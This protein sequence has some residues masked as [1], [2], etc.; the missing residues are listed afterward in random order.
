MLV[1]GNN[2]I[3]SRLY[4]QLKLEFNNPFIWMVLTYDSVYYLMSNW[5]SMNFDKF[6]I[7]ASKFKNN[8]FVLIIDGKVELHFVHYV[9]DKNAN[10][11]F[12]EQKYTKDGAWYGNV[13]FKNI[14]SYIKEKYISRLNRMKACSEEPVFLLRD[15][16]YAVNNYSSKTM[17]DLANH[18]SK[19]KRLIITR[20]RSITRNDEVCK[21]IYIDKLDTLEHTVQTYI[22]EIT[23]FLK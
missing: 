22:T 13:R 4:E 18:T 1:I 17:K 2:C 19:Y 8:T 21:T 12:K 23:S 15:E 16:V 20:D 6:V 9:F 10:T 11:P 5:N 14:V 3:S 7:E